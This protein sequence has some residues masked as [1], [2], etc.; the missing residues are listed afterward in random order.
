VT[1]VT[2]FIPGLAR[3]EIVHGVR[4]IRVPV[5]FR[6]KLE[7]ANIPSM[8]CY[9]LSSVSKVLSEFRKNHFD[10][11][12]THFAIPS[13]P[14]G[15]FL[16]KCFGIPNVLSIHG[17]DIYDPSKSTS[18]HKA[19][20]L[21]H[22]VRITL[23]AASRVVAQS[24]NTKENASNYYRVKRQ[25]DVIPLGI[26]KPKFQ[27]KAR[28]DYNLR[29]DEA[30]FC[31]IGRLVKRKNIG[32]TLRVLAKLNDK[33][34]FKFIIIGDG[35]ERRGLE[36]EIDRLKL[37]K[38]VYFLG[39]VSDQE[40]FQLLDLSDVYLSTSMHEGFGLVFLEAMAC[41]LPIIC[42]DYGGQTD[43]LRDERNG[44]LT[45][46]GDLETFE[47]RIVKL[48]NYKDL[49]ETIGRT[50]RI[51]ASNFYIYRCAEKYQALFQ[52]VFDDS[53]GLKQRLVK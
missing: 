21:S 46:V 6:K 44:Y 51:Q 16:S 27:K 22:T 29:E 50:N 39:N 36:A 28:L 11:I 18:P 4:V 25:I 53:T 12:N 8:L 14:A 52:E 31:T 10:I 2:S 40:K 45:R 19:P 43:F 35:P 15:Q 17:G 32:D 33:F 3:D 7:V 13:G 42:H 23:K 1:V 37:E 20:L 26:K 5:F 30:V 38:R 34:P 48:I 41:G 24:N 49:R 9:P 47:K